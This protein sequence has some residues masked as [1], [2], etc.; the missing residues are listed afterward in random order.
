MR[1]KA[2]K[3]TSFQLHTMADESV[4]LKPPAV[5]GIASMQTAEGRPVKADKDGG[6]ALKRGVTYVVRFR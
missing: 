6:F 1:W 4:R 2:G 5:E 3:I